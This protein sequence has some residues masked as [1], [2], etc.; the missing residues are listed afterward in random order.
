MA[1][2]PDF[3]Q[4]KTICVHSDTRGAADLLR[5]VRGAL[6]AGVGNAVACGS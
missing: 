3:A 2:S 6:V 1:E 5:A 4:I